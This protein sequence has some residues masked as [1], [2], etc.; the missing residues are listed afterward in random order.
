MLNLTEFAATAFMDYEHR[1]H[2]ASAI[3]KAIAERVQTMD[4]AELHSALVAADVPVMLLLQPS[5]LLRE[6]AAAGR[7][8]QAHD[9]SGFLRFPVQLAGMSKVSSSSTAAQ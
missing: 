9:G 4:S 3:R 5:G 6:S 1:A 8:L 2:H 7:Q